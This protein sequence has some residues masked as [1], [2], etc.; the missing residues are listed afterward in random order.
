MALKFRLRGLAE[1]FI[2]AITCPECGV[3]GNDDV[4][5]ATDQTRVTFEGIIVVVQCKSCREI[6]VPRE[7]RLGV[8][9]PHELRAAVFKDSHDTGEPVMESLTAVRLAVEKLNAQRKGDMH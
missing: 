4:Q 9:S 2:E 8:L 3:T 1:T 5:F 6:F 7:Q